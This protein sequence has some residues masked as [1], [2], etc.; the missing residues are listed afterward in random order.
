M[1][2]EGEQIQTAPRTPAQHRRE[3][4]DCTTARR[5]LAAY[6]LWLMYNGSSKLQLLKKNWKLTD[7]PFC[8]PLHRPRCNIILLLQGL[9]ST[10]WGVQLYFCGSAAK[11]VALCKVPMSETARK[12]D[13]F[14]LS[15]KLFLPGLLFSG[16]CQHAHRFFFPSKSKIAVF[17]VELSHLCSTQS[18]E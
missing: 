9:F 2:W 13:Y 3:E 8:F 6:L 16:C 12:V 5:N 15:T 14:K 18:S 17:R 1:R 11:Q 4:A 7:I 10:S